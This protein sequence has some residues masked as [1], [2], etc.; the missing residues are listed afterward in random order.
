MNCMHQVASEI[1]S[2]LSHHNVNWRGVYED[3]EAALQAHQAAVNIS[4]S[5]RY[6]LNYFIDGERFLDL[7]MII[8]SAFS[9]FGDEK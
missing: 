1:A 6:P 2:T 9:K 8:S 5:S 4:N 3:I 7:T